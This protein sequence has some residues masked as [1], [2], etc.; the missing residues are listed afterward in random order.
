M[1]TQTVKYN[2]RTI[3]YDLVR[4][5]VK[6]INLRIRPDGSIT[7]SAGERVPI[8]RVQ[9]FILS[10]AEYILHHL[11]E[12]QKKQKKTPLRLENGEVFPFLGIN[13]NITVISERCER[14]FLDGDNLCICTLTPDD[15][16]AKARLLADFLTGQCA[17][18]FTKIAREIFPLLSE[19]NLKTPT[20]KAKNMSSRWGSC[21]PS[22]AAITLNKRL[23]FAPICCIEYVVLHEF[24]HLEHADHSKRFYAMLSSFMP[25]YKERRHMLRMMNDEE[26]FYVY[27]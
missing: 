20:L 15:Y 2:G 23:I 25:D 27:L 8:K 1:S 3:C 13:R 18:I 7:V 21:S 24:C 19:Y 16:D 5:R 12:F 10:K 26:I 17:E 4:K 6:N 14:V 9:E 22:R 11:D